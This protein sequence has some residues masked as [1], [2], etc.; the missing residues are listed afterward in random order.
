MVV[1]GAYIIVLLSE[2]LPNFLKRMSVKE[3][4][5]EKFTNWL[6][7]KIAKQNI[8]LKNNYLLTMVLL[9]IVQLLSVNLG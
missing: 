3:N 8:I 4:G 9:S 1:G 2:I 7:R 6:V 5:V